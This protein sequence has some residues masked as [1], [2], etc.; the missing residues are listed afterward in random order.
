MPA[1]IIL[2]DTDRRSLKR[3]ERLLADFDHLVAAASTFAEAKRL[4]YTINPDLLIADVRLGAFNGLHLAVRSRLDHPN[5]PVII[6][7]DSPDVVLEHE[8]KR[9]HA[10]FVVNPLENPEFLRVVH[11]LLERHGRTQ[12]PLR[13]WRR[14]QVNRLLEAELTTVR[15]RVCDVSYGGLRLAF[16]A[17]QQL[18]DVFDIIFP[19]VGLTVKARHV[20][21]VR[22]PMTDEYWCGAE[23]L[24]SRGSGLIGWRDIVD[25]A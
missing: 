9:Q 2:V 16:G 1:L 19:D 18:P 21:T 13:R 5:V 11:S 6:T 20:W 14:K 4:L 7:N 15:A 12:Q 25:S 8:V 17:E 23:V 3:K 22:S 24:D 10:T